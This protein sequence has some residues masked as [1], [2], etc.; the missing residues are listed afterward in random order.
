MKK[1]IIIIAV[2]A[3]IVSIVIFPL[4][5][6]SQ[7][8]SRFKMGTVVE[9]TLNGPI[10]TNFDKIFEKAFLAI[11]KAQNL[12]DRYNQGSQISIVNR[13]AHKFPVVVDKE[14]YN[15]IENATSISKNTE[16]A[17]DIT[18]TPLVELW[19]FYKKQGSLPSD[20]KIKGA[21]A[22]VGF[23][24][25]V[26]DREKKAVFLKKDGVGL[27][28]SAIAKGYA[29]DKA[30]KVIRECGISSA[31]INAGGDIYCVGKKN[32]FQKWNVGIKDPDDNK[33]IIKVIHV[34][35]RAVA[36]SGGYEKFLTRQG[37]KYSHLID[38]RTGLPAEISRNATVVAR[39]CTLAD[40][41]ATA[42][43]ILSKNKIDQ[44]KIKYD[45]EV[46]IK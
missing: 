44:L 22:R 31:I 25:I 7:R 46:F 38:P 26:L 15:L 20:A 27:D 39:T 9:I 24:N 23:N 42:L 28:L 8:R 4:F 29:V 2:T 40:A 1:I 16:G 11:D 10:W 17:F 36:T 37:E 19:G 12:A 45:I 18:V 30:A 3:L 14:L 41:L 13:E 34:R 33:K 43:C 5:N 35:D 21:L 32:I 6:K